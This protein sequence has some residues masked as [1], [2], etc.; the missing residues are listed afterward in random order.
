MNRGPSALD[1]QVV[2][3]GDAGDIRLAPE[4]YV[5]YMQAIDGNDKISIQRR[6]QLSRYF[7]EFC[8]HAHFFKRL[9]ELKFK[10]EGNFAVGNSSQMTATVWA[11][12]AWKWRLYGAILQVD[13]RRCFVGVNVDPNK[14]KDKADPKMLRDTAHKIGAL[15]EFG[16]QK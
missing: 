9:S 8:D 6:T 7:R 13:A 5:D 2:C 10:N 12:K 14:K 11:F 4:T 15:L 16:G 3:H 1:Y